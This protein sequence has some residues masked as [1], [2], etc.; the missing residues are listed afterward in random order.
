MNFIPE[1]IR[2][3]QTTLGGVGSILAGGALI[4]SAGA[5]VAQALASGHAPNW[6]QDGEHLVAGLGFISAG[7]VGLRAPDANKIG[8]AAAQ[9]PDK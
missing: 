7:Y 8:I 4:L 6:D 2:H 1:A 3:I 9:D 5:E